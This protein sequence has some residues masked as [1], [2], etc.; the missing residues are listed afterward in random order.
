MPWCRQNCDFGN[1]QRML[2][3]QF[4]TWLQQS[5][6]LFN[7]IPL[8]LG[9]HAL[10]FGPSDQ[11]AR[12]G[13]EYAL[14]TIDLSAN[15]IHMVRMQMR[16]ENEVDIRRGQFRFLQARKEF[17]TLK[18]GV[19][20]KGNL[21]GTEA[22]INQ[23]V[24]ARCLDTIGADAGEDLHILIE[25]VLVGLPV[26]KR[27]RRVQKRGVEECI[28][29][30]QIRDPNGTERNMA[31]WCCCDHIYFYPCNEIS[32]LI[33][34]RSNNSSMKKKNGASCY[35]FGSRDRTIGWDHL[36]VLHP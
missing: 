6:G 14:F 27:R 18:K 19:L 11:K 10:P 15:P 2:F 24:V 36:L 17:A 16:Q 5:D 35:I 33:R 13:V 31:L 3:N 21:T 29:I 9:L 20:F 25:Q 26:C 7:A 1:K 32:F 12:I 23:D 30:R 4:N 22:C 8:S 28:A 34:T